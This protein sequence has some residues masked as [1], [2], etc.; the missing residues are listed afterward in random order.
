MIFLIVGKP[1]SGKTQ[2]AVKKIFDQIELN[3]K[4]LD[5]IENGEE[6]DESKNEV[7]RPIYSDIEGLNIQGVE[8][9]PDDWRTVPNDSVIFYDEVHY[10]KEYEDLTGKPSQDPMIK[11]LTTHGHK[12]IDLYLITQASS[13]IERS[14]R[15]LVDCIYYA[16][17]PQQKP[18]FCTIYEFD[19]F[20]NEPAYAAQ[21]G[22]EHDKYMFTFKDKYQ[23]AYKSASAHTSVKFKVQRKFIWAII[24][25]VVMAFLS[26]KLML[27]GGFIDL[28]KQGTGHAEQKTSDVDSISSSSPVPTQLSSDLSVEC[29]KGANIDKPGCVKWFDDL[30]KNRASISTSD[31]GRTF[32]SYSPDKPFDNT[33]IQKNVN[34]EVTARPVFSGCMYRN[35]RY[36]AYTQQGTILNGVSQDDCKRLMIDNDRPF[37]YFAT[38]QDNR[39]AFDDKS[40]E[41]SSL[42]FHSNQTKT[43]EVRQEQAQ[44]YVQE[45][46]QAQVV[47]GSNAL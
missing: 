18:K 16:K 20:Y 7:I 3:K 34:Y 40:N 45:H 38:Q 32:I 14:I 31:N 19:K 47:N 2:F 24:A 12:N 44:N 17:R 36:V 26:V 30:T 39:T 27:S 4:Y 46:L 10:R 22:L 25:I 42:D 43:N 15:G 28:V 35:G 21:K 1:R 11:D 6:L 9:A 5:K 29:R 41:R 37:N 33:D 8:L 13:R 23:N